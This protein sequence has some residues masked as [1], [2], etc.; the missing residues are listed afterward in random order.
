M[1]AS[2]ESILRALDRYGEQLQE[3]PGVQGVGADSAGLVVYVEDA[4]LVDDRIPS[5]VTVSDEHGCKAVVAVRIETIG[6]I[7]LE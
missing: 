6:T 4:E 5:E 7:T 3:L 2:Y 1:T